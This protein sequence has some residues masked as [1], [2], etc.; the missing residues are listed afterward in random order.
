MSLEIGLAGSR[1]G[2]PSAAGPI[3]SFDD[4]ENGGYYWFLY[5]LFEQLAEKTG[6]MIDLYGDAE[7]RG[8]AL[9]S[10]RQTLHEA[11]RLVGDQPAQW[12]VFVGTQT[13]P[14]APKPPPPRDIFK[15]VERSKLLALLDLM[16]TIVDRASSS[17]MAVVCFGD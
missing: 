8:D 12:S 1:P 5:P 2:P 16:L 6:Q 3:A 13:M 10:L 14:N 7:F 11:C 17:G 9:Q 4:D 15:D